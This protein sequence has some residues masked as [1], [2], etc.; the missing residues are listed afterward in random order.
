[1]TSGQTFHQSVFSKRWPGLQAVTVAL[2]HQHRF[3]QV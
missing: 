3:E 2:A 1:M